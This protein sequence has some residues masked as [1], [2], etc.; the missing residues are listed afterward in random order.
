MVVTNTCFKQEKRRR[1][2]WKAPGDIERYQLDYIMV[3]QRFRNSVKNSH[4]CPR[5]DADTDHNL[6]IMTAFLTLKNV[7]YKKQNIKRW[8]KEN[9]NTK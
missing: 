5:A 3:R 9:I 2:T 7:K 6:V 4:A 1:Y 8:D